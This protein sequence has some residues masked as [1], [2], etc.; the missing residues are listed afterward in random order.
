MIE[1][2]LL[3]EARLTNALLRAG[4]QDRIDAVSRNVKQDAVSVAILEFLAENG[5]TPSA[6][7]KDA[8]AAKLRKDTE[9]SSRTISRRIV[10]LEKKGLIW[11]HGHSSNTTYEST[12]VV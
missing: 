6:G 3:E 12:G 8:V 4:F 2:E 11:Q 5:R 7:L 9:V 10:E 1:E